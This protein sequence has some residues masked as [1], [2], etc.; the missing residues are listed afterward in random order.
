MVSVT[1]ER[2][3]TPRGELAL[4]RA[5][6]HH[7]IVSNGVFLMDT[8]DGRSGRE[9]VRAALRPAARVPGC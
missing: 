8:R 7:E 1:V 4:R 9:L 6:G 5:G 2:L 3:E